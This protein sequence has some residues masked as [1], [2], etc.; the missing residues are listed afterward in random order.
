[1]IWFGYCTSIYCTRMQSWHCTW[2]FFDSS[3]NIPTSQLKVVCLQLV[4]YIANPW[5]SQSRLAFLRHSWRCGAYQRY[6][7][8]MALLLCNSPGNNT[9]PVES[10]SVFYAMPPVIWVNY[11]F[12]RS[13]LTHCLVSLSGLGEAAATWLWSSGPG[14]DSGSRE[15]SSMP[16]NIE[17]SSTS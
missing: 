15:E 10:L 16:M 1:M 11:P 13:P 4:L 7:W 6:S 8:V 2:A 5:N 3:P 9:V 14:R 17:Q 12:T